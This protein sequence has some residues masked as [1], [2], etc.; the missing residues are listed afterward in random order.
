MQSVAI[1]L[2]VSAAILI[3]GVMWGAVVGLYIGVVAFVLGSAVQVGWLWL[4]VQP[5]LGRLEGRDASRRVG[6]LT[7]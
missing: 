5:I 3:G 2:V 6:T 4:K 7:P 1:S